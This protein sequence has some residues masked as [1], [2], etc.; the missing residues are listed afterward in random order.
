MLADLFRTPLNERQIKDLEVRSFLEMGERDRMG[1]RKNAELV[2][3]ITCRI[4]PESRI[5]FDHAFDQRRL[6]PTR[7]PRRVGRRPISGHLDVCN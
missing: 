6:S 5:T 2:L 4:G 1:H 3:L 7:S